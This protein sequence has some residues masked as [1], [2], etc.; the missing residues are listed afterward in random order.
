MN[1]KDFY[2][3]TDIQVRMS[4]LDPFAHVNNG[5]QCH[6]FDY[7]R[8]AYFEHVF[9]GKIDWAALDL[10]IA[11]L[12]LDFL[13]PVLFEDDMV[14]DCKIYEIGNKSM[15]MIQQLRDVNTNTIKTT[16][17]SVIV[18]FD[19][20]NKTAIPIQTTYKEKITLF[21]NP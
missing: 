13:H 1:K 9:E 16:C 17:K 18:G 3:T 2:F 12:E 15:K 20:N 21:E 19:R 7:G 14:C 10:V 5:A 4:D 11:H 6:L 8:S